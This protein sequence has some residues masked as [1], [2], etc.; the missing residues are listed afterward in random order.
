MLH[1][2]WGPS[3]H[4]LSAF[5]GKSSSRLM[6][7]PLPGVPSSAHCIGSSPSSAPRL[8]PLASISSNSQTESWS[9]RLPT[10][11]ALNC[12]VPQHM[13]TCTHAHMH[14]SMQ[15]LLAMVWL[16]GGSSSGFFVCSSPARSFCASPSLTPHPSPSPS[17]SPSPAGL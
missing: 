1:S 11:S 10:E 6:G 12:R 5:R 4:W 14:T 3:P 15:S 8:L 2:I 17:L 13:H 7:L 16:C 9:D